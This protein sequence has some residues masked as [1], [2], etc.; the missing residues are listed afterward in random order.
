MSFDIYQV[1][2]IS[3]KL[4]SSC[5]SSIFPPPHRPNIVRCQTLGLQQLHAEIIASKKW[6][7]SSPVYSTSN[8]HLSSSGYPEW[9]A[10]HKPVIC[11]RYRLDELH[12]EGTFSRIYIAED[13]YRQKLVA[14][15]L[16]KSGLKML[17]LREKCFLEHLA[18]D[19]K[20]GISYC[21]FILQS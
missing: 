4:N 1:K 10:S 9:K 18:V 12:A 14:I 19:S 11:K 5:S 17:A 3:V 6:I 7:S 21:K 16:V 8:Y 20:R 13:L 15:K 2:P